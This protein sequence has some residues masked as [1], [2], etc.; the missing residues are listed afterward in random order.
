MHRE[1]QA[2]F[3]SAL[4]YGSTSQGKLVDVHPSTSWRWVRASV[5]RAEDLGVIVPARKIGTHTLRHSFARHLVMN[6]I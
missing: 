6:G 1:L 5:R 3:R 4:S 2:A